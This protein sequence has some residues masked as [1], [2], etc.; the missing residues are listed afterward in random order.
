[1]LDLTLHGNDE[2]NDEIQEEDGPEDWHVEYT[3][4]RHAN[5]GQHR[6]CARVPELEL[7]ESSCKRSGVRSNVKQG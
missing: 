1:M 5:G 4:E 3:K 2:E 7:R 6:P